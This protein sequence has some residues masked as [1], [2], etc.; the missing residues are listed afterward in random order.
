MPW[1]NSRARRA[2]QARSTRMAS[3]RDIKSLCGFQDLP[4]AN[5]IRTLFDRPSTDQIHAPAENARQFLLHLHPVQQRPRRL[6]RK[7]DKNIH[8][9]IRAK[10]GTEYRPKQRQLGD[11]P[12]PAE[13]RY[14][15]FGDCKSGR[16]HGIS[17]FPWLAAC[18]FSRSLRNLRILFFASH[19]SSISSSSKVR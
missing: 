7:G 18:A 4:P 6:G 19:K 16:W 12:A 1:T 3:S 2:A 8:V 11:V 9:A 15:L 5:G 13:V 17:W 10:I 14:S